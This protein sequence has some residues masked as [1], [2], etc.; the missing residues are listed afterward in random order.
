MD[1]NA[2]VAVVSLILT[3]VVSP[4][5]LLHFIPDLTRFLISAVRQRVPPG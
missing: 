4:P 3:F 5:F 2:T 1:T